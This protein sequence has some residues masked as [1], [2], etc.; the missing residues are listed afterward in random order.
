MMIPRIV[1]TAII[2]GSA[3]LVCSCS[4]TPGDAAHNGGH[5]EQAA[6]LYEA[7]VKQGDALAAE[8]LGNLYYHRPGLPLD[9]QQAIYWYEKAISLGDISPICW[10]GEIYRDGTN[11]IPKDLSKARHWFERGAELGQHYSMYNLAD[12]YASEGIQPSNDVQGL[13]WLESVLRLA[14]KFTPQNEGTAY[15]LRDPKSVRLRLESRMAR[16]DIAQATRLASDWVTD[17]EQSHAK[18]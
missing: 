6:E 10:I 4:T 2:L 15:I 7:G 8:K 5:F 16:T 12:L 18:K 1:F 17:F 14:R 3:C 9:H 13:M 11:N